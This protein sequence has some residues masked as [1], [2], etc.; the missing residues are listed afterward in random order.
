MVATPHDIIGFW[1]N[2]GP[3]K[4]YA[5]STAFDEA[6]RL[7]FEPTHHAAARGEYDAWSETAEG[8][9]ALLILLDQFP[10]NLYRGSGHAFATD[11]KARQIARAA[12][13]NGWHL[14]CEA[15]F[16]Q[17]FLLPFEHSEDP[18]DQE[19]SVALARELG[20]PETLKWAEIHRDIIV[21][22]GRFPHRNP[23]LGR[24]TTPEEQ[25]FLDE[26]GFAG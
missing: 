4:W 1:R 22:F 6:I 13:A 5:R 17:F 12:V 9:L 7:K 3:S 21:R 14:S 15:P 11:G 16:G 19:R 26:G 18:A 10:R 25:Q 20:D 23:A 2:A 8:A 24:V